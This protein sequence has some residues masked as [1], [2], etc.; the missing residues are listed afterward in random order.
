LNLWRD[1]DGS[2]LGIG[3]TA[4]SFHKS[5]LN[6]SI[7][8]LDP[9]VHCFAEKYFGLPQVKGEVAFADGRGYI[10]DAARRGETWDFVVHDVF[11]GGKVPERL[12]TREMWRATKEV[13]KENGVLAVVGL[14]YSLFSP[15]F[16]SY[17]MT[18]IPPTPFHTH[19][20]S[21]PAFLSLVFLRSLLLSFGSLSVLL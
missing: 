18:L 12:F 1:V 3:T 19:L 2:G 4:K 20:A 9:L 7:V 15:L 14:L 11:T 5:G 10:E 13:L 16:L 8:E 17:S 6:V 21:I